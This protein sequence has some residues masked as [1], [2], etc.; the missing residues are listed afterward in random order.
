MIHLNNKTSSLLENRKNLL[1]FSAGVDSSA[2]FFLLRENN[3]SFDIALVNYHLREQS[4][5]EEKHALEL[6]K[7]HQLQAHIIQAPSFDNNFEKNARDFRYRFFDKLMKNYDNLLTAHQLNDQLEWFLMRLTKGAGTVELMGL[8]A[9]SKRENYQLIRPLLHH[10]KEELLNYLNE[11]QYPYFIDES[12]HS[13][14]Y[15]RNRFRKNFSDRLIAQYQKGISRS[16]NYLQ[17]DKERLLEGVQELFHRQ[18]FY[19]L[20]CN[21]SNKLRVIDRYLKKLGYLLSGEQRKTLE[22]EPSMV[23][24]GLWAIEQKNNQIYIAPYLKTSMP[25][26]FKE[27]CRL[28]NIPIKIRPYLYEKNLNPKEIGLKANQSSQ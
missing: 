22:K 18:E 4:Q 17:E 11:A 15:E 3:I 24:G 6:A 20:N 21:E 1:A 16:F 19:L 27:S 13:E 8:E 28:S 26:S 7:Q 14:K 25:K 10:S 12:N 9:I 23:I 2:L 5:E